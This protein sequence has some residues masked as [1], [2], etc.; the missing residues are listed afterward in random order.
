MPAPLEIKLN[1]EEDRTL[2]ELSCADG[3]PYRCKQRAMALRLNAHGWKVPQIANYLNWHEHTV[4]NTLKRWEQKGLG[5]LW[6]ASGR[7]RKRCWSEADWQA[8]EQWVGEARRYS[9]S[10]ISHKLLTQRQVKLGAEQVRRWL[11]K[12]GGSGSEFAIV[13]H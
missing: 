6:E 2:K 11:K 3:V 4:R 12:K 9:A 8:V 1:E 5:G 10:Q 13:Q 7:G